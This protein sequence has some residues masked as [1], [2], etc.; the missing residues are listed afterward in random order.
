MEQ[1]TPPPNNLGSNDQNVGSNAML[2]PVDHE[3]CSSRVAPLSASVQTPTSAGYMHTPSTRYIPGNTSQKPQEATLPTASTGLT[4]FGRT[5]P[6]N[7]QAE[8][9]AFLTARNYTPIP[10]VP[11][12]N[13]QL[14]YHNEEELE[15]PEESVA[16]EEAAETE[17][18]AALS[19]RAVLQA[20]KK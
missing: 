14:V 7:I 13:S 16:N 8:F 15:D 1:V 19:F 5:T 10:I 2:D 3:A 6:D 9:A 12:H 20:L 18:P 4:P 17:D 11:P